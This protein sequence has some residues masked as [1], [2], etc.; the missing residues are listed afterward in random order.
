MPFGDLGVAEVYE[1]DL[2]LVG[3][4]L[5]VLFGVTFVGLL[6]CLYITLDIFGVGSY[7]WIFPVDPVMFLI[8]TAFAVSFCQICCV[9]AMNIKAVSKD[10]ASNVAKIRM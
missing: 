5:L 1:D 10:S 6:L 4:M 9:K 2:S 8:F 3:F 7:I